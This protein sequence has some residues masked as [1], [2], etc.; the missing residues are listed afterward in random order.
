MLQNPFK[1]MF[2]GVKVKKRGQEDKQDD[3]VMG[4]LEDSDK[5]K[6]N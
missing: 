5:R 4:L 3:F 1:N 6:G 2:A